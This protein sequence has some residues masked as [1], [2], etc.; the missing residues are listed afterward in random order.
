MRTTIIPFLITSIGLIGACK[1]Y[2]KQD[3]YVECVEKLHRS[4]F[5]LKPKVSKEAAEWKVVK[6]C[7]AE[8]FP[9][10]TPNGP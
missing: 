3:R 2:T 1:T 8:F 4:L 9:A 7:A 5:Y 6:V 10:F